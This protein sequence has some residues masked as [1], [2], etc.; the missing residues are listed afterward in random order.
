MAMWHKLGGLCKW[1]TANLVETPPMDSL[2]IP[3]VVAN[4]SLEISVESPY[5]HPVELQIGADIPP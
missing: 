3:M 4:S 1:Q 5:G 2:E